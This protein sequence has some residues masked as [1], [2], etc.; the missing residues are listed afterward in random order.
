MAEQQRITV[1][2]YLGQIEAGLMKEL[3]T[4]KEAL[5]P[6]FNRE[7]FILNCVTVI[8]GMLR[9]KRKAK[10]LENVNINSIVT[11]LVQGAYLGLD[12]FNGECYA[13]PY[14][15]QMNFQ[16]D[17]KGEIKL[18]KKYSKEPIRD[19]FAKL[20]RA[21]DEFS[22][23]VDNGEQKIYFRPIAFS[24]AEPIG[25]FAVVKFKDGSMSYE[26]MG[27]EEIEHVRDTYSRARDSQA[28]TESKGEMYK[29]T[30][31]RRLCKCIDLNFDNIEQRVAYENGGDCEFEDTAQGTLALPEKETP[32]NVMSQIQES[33]KKAPVKETPVPD[34]PAPAAEQMEEREMFDEY[35]AYEEQYSEVDDIDASE[36]PWK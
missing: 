27:K 10:S 4:H 35:A 26:T 8:R 2:Q 5:P 32:V 30:V 31:L 14:S 15:G 29:K 12:F 36:L 22:E 20:V 13:I 34:T 19:I 11:A 23:E 6:G 33:K 21:G 28:W 3:T 24:N 16:T 9:D 7:R 25:A 1:A 18:C 17:Y